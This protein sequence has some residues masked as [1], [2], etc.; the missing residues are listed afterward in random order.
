MV[1]DC[2]YAALC[3]HGFMIVVFLWCSRF[4]RSCAFV[5]MFAH[6]YEGVCVLCCVSSM[7][8][9]GIC[10]GQWLLGVVFGAGLYAGVYTVISTLL[11]VHIP[12]SYGILQRRC[13]LPAD[14][15]I[16][17]YATASSLV[18]CFGTYG[19]WGLD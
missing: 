11:I 7:P 9:D 12:R 8:P 4:F 10:T 6:I 16:A 1:S 14:G 3:M 18:S 13:Y 2:F 5:L 15:S 19:L 17:W